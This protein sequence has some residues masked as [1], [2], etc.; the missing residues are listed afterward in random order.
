MEFNQV[1]L[2]GSQEY[3]KME[4]KGIK[5]SHVDMEL[6]WKLEILIC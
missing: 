2:G 1:Q 6:H 5:T 3:Q 4:V